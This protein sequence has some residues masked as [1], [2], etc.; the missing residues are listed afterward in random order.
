MTLMTGAFQETGLDYMEYIGDMNDMGDLD[1]MDDRGRAP[2]LIFL[3]VSPFILH[4]KC[5]V[6]VRTFFCMNLR[7]KE[8][9]L[10]LS[11]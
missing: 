3:P 6:K 9:N 8:Q 10:K 1:D 2:L 11:T 4:L 5:L 7:Q